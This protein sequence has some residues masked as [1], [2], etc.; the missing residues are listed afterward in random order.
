[1]SF[2]EKGPHITKGGAKIKLIQT[3]GA[4]YLP[5][6]ASTGQAMLASALWSM[7]HDRMGYPGNK[8]LSMLASK[9]EIRIIGRKGFPEDCTHCLLSK[10]RRTPVRTAAT[11][12]GNNVVQVDVMPWSTKGWKGEKYAAVFSHRSS[13]LD[14]VFIYSRKGEATR[15]L[16][17][18]L[19]NIRPK[20]AAPPDTIQTDTGAEF[21]SY[22]WKQICED[23]GMVVRHCPVDHQAMNGQTERSQGTLASMTRAML[24]ARQ[25]PEK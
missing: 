4:W 19:V 8:K 13:K 17:E 25:V 9:S 24:Q 11:P 14:A 12:S 3:K 1:M 18:Y 10:P 6:R 15:A 21:L 22:E 16:K 23:E 20:L 7:W 5:P 2:S